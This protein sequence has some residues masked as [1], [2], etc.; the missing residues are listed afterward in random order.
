MVTISLADYSTKQNPVYFFH[1]LDLFQMSKYLTSCL[2]TGYLETYRY[3]FF[4]VSNS[5]SLTEES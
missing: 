2:P 4:H 1:E 3:E 5:S